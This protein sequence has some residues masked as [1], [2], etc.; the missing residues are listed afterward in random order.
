MREII[1]AATAALAV[2]AGGASAAPAKAVPTAERVVRYKQH[3]SFHNWY[4]A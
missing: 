2:L 4:S 3:Y 1:L